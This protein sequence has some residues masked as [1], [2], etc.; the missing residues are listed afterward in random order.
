MQCL[1]EKDLQYDYLIYPK[2][3]KKLEK[4]NKIVTYNQQSVEVFARQ[5][6]VEQSEDTIWINDLEIGILNRL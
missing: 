4:D 3:Q 2:L 6:S 1:T 5:E